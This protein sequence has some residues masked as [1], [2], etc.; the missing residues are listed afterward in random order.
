M[1]HSV[2]HGFGPVS[3]SGRFVRTRGA[4]QASVGSVVDPLEKISGKKYRGD[5]AGSRGVIASTI[6]YG[7]GDVNRGVRI[8]F[9]VN[10]LPR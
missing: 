8:N 1:G 9:E 6:V 5:P 2:G 10:G 7:L 3:L 4:W